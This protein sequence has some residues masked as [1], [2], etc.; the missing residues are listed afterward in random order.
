MEGNRGRTLLLTGVKGGVRWTGG[1]GCSDN[2]EAKVVVVEVTRAKVK[3]GRF[4]GK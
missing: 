1:V 4:M 2:E 3:W